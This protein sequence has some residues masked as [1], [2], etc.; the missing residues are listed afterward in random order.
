MY[1]HNGQNKHSYNLNRWYLERGMYTPHTPTEAKRSTGL[2]QVMIILA[3]SQANIG[4][5]RESRKEQQ[6]QNI[7]K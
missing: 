4:A 6:Q 7:K 2:K 1:A 5:R 3:H